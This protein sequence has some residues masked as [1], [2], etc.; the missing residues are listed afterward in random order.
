MRKIF[1]FLIVLGLCGCTEATIYTQS[2]RPTNPGNVA[3]LRKARPSC[4]YEEMGHIKTGESW[5]F[6]SALNKAREKAAEHGADGIILEGY[7]DYHGWLFATMYKCSSRQNS[8]NPNNAK[9]F[10]GI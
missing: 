4:Q 10:Y 7:D 2:Y 6:S 9:M 8:I 5:S 1:Y 3:V